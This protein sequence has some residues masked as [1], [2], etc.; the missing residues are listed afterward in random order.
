M[1]SPAQTYKL[2]ERSALKAILLATLIAG[3]LDILAAIVSYTIKGGKE[4]VKI[5]YFIASGVFGKDMA[6]GS[7]SGM[8]VAGLLF[9]YM[10]ALLFAI[11]LFFVYPSLKSFL[12]NKIV[13]GLLYG[14]FVWL[15]MNKIV[16]PLSN[17]P[18]LPFNVKG[19]VIGALILMFCIGLPL[20][21]IIDK[22][23]SKWR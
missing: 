17:S 2:N 8:A 4:P 5:F 16:L 23:Y 18:A 7:G 9:H 19:A 15:V 14:I 1:S 10:I 20:A 22:F 6:Y 11:F 21:L 12:K 3:T 13:I